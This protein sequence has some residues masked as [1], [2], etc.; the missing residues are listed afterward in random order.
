[1]VPT[2]FVTMAALPLTANGK[3]DH[4]ALPTPGAPV[5]PPIDARPGDPTPTDT[6]P[7]D[8]E[9]AVA[10][11][12]AELLG[13][14]HVGADDDFFALGGHSLLAIRLMLRLRRAFDLDLPAD[15]VFHRRTARGLAAALD[16]AL[17]SAPW[18]T[19]RPVRRGN[20]L[21]LSFGQQRMWF[22]DRLEPGGS[23]YLI[24]LAL[25][26]RGPWSPEVLRRAM[27]DVV[28]RHEILRTRYTEDFT[29][30][31]DPP[32][33]VAF[34][35]ADLAGA[36]GAE[37]R[38]RR[39]LDEAASRPFDLRTEHPV[40]I[41]VARI[42]EHDHL[43][44]VLVHHI[45]SDQ[46]S[47]ELL[48][49]ELDQTYRALAAGE[50]A[51]LR[52]QPVQYADYAAWQ[53]GPRS[54]AA[55]DAQLDYWRTALADLA[56]VEL[57]TDRPRPA[58]RDIDGGRVSF[59]V[60]PGVVDAVG[61][62]GRRRDC[63]P[64][65]TVLAAFEV[66]LARLTGLADVAVGTPV[67]GRTQP[68]VENLLGFFVNHLVMRC[69]LSGDPA[70]TGVLDRVR[71]VVLTGMANQDVPFERVV[72]ALRP[73]RDLSRNP[74][75]QI[76]FELDHAAV[77]P[78]RLCGAAAEP[79]GAGV[80]VA[81]FDLRL[82]TRLLD[83]GALRC[84]LEYATALFDRS[85]V[86]RMA[87]QFTR[88][89]ESIAAAPDAPVSALDLLTPEQ[90][91]TV[92]HEW[93][94]PAAGLLEHVDPP[95][96]HR[97]GVAAMVEEQVRRAPDA[98]AVIY[99]DQRLT[100]AELN[101]RANRLAHHLR[102]LGVAPETV[103]GCLMERGADAIVVWLA[104]L[105]SGGVYLPIDPGNPP[106]RVSFLLA[107]TGA[108]VVLTTTGHAAEL[109]PGPYTVVTVDG[110][111]AWADDPRAGDPA[112][113]A[114]LSSLA[115]I[116]YTSGS[117][118]RPKGVMID[119][120]AYAHHCRAIS[121]RYRSGP[122]DRVLLL[123]ALTFDVAMDQIAVPLVNGSTLIVSD[124]WFWSP[125]DLL[126]KVRE[127]GVTTMQI[128]PGYYREI[129]D[130]D[131]SAL[132]G[133]TLMNVG[134]D[135]VTTADARRWTEAGLTGRF[136]Y[137]YGPTE[138]TV[139]CVV[140]TVGPGLADGRAKAGLPIGVPLAG[141]PAY[142]LDAAMRPVPVGAPG[143][144]YVGGVRLAR[145]Y[146]DRPGLTAE[147]FLPDPFSGTPGARLYR[148]GDLARH[149]A[150]GTIEFLGRLDHQVKIR[151][152]RIELGEIEATL[153][154]H[155]EVRTVVVV[156]RQS[157]AGDKRLV[158]YVV[159]RAEAGATVADL[160]AHVGQSLPEYMVPAHWVLLDALPL[161]S[162]K[163]VDRKALPDPSWT[164]VDG[165]ARVAPSTP[166]QRAVATAWMQALGTEDPSIHDDFFD[167]G[168]HSLLAARL[169]GSLRDAF[170]VDIP[171]RLLFENTTI[172]KAATAITD[173][174]RAQIAE[175]SAEEAGAL[176]ARGRRSSPD[177]T[178]PMEVR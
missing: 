71:E 171:L 98:P 150:G 161:T 68:A 120:R 176:A 54:T 15:Q 62:V 147:R 25:R 174:L 97:L 151:G 63:T 16:S 152:F 69:D 125:E 115:Y 159:T 67:A 111:L 75:F 93:A 153:R 119:H 11:F 148:T 50:P 49:R 139:N 78:D 76:V 36:A 166:A 19:I 118:G 121:E 21:A 95:A 126:A 131:V 168:G 170:A 106:Q 72:D 44:L 132:A 84:T 43:L 137:N 56:A 160:R 39:R 12:M 80:P 109:Q 141:S 40:R 149:R 2:A 173:L 20:G 158:A 162:S 107:D 175:L 103:V 45:A 123:S 73:D 101:A 3:L 122:D 87:A 110:S 100:Y 22:V 26:L 114:E 53:R 51:P 6:E 7:T 136:L 142:V 57:P 66:L 46:W 117:T 61:A 178:I 41:T 47:S 23:E 157:P 27:D 128:T 172:A 4:A 85:T 154:R 1:M 82:T 64:F 99:A 38:A 134:A 81:K 156:A 140:H 65:V 33:P 42:A 55:V 10:G 5:A 116:I 13:V 145:G 35:L 94:D 14:P 129:M 28:A 92:L 177:R 104:V 18:D 83:S 96:V 17:G 52:A 112:P 77:V 135:V 8:T 167:L 102:D 32:G 29:Q 37:D 59:T 48:M 58:H 79:I 113:A 30:V 130:R 169:A 146:H 86:E 70:F 138:A 24:P 31:V 155:A 91:H 74:L 127:H 165:V 89:L 88:L 164:N 124:P 34:D 144:L 60:P 163:K 133:I 9:L 108:P 90:R 105:K 143:E